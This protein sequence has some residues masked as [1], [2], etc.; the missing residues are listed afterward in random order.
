MGVIW[1]AEDTRLGRTVALKLLTA[2]LARDPGSKARFL[3]EARTAST[4]DHVNVCSIYEVGE[5]ADLQLYLAMPFYE[6]ETLEERIDRG[7]LGIPEVIDV[8][9]QAA[10]GL[11]KAHQRGIVHRDVKP[12]NLMITG[13]GVVKILDFGIAKLA[14]DTSGLTRGGTVVG[15]PAYMSPEQMEGRPVDPR[16]DLWSLGVVIYE[17]LTGCQ[18]FPGENAT[19]ARAAIL[20]GEPVPLRRLR[21]DVPAKLDRLVSSLL[22][23]DPAE[24]HAV[25]RE[26]RGR[27]AVHARRTVPAPSARTG[28]ARLDPPPPPGPGSGPGGDPD[29]CR[30]LPEDGAESGAEAG[31]DSREAGLSPTRPAG[32]RPAPVRG[33]AGLQEPLGEHRATVARPRSHGDADGGAGGRSQIAGRVERADGPGSTH[34][35]PAGG[36]KPG[37]HCPWN[38]S[39]P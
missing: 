28:A 6:G 2:E 38:A 20:Q 19:A 32:S 21:P 8:A 9:L 15:T 34:P 24:P 35:Q 39:T 10:R 29:R 30:Q 18:P 33:G 31:R 25:R 4:L 13:D 27:S 14:S 16:T 22:K 5:T 3:Q 1:R 7:P 36:R 11:G 37:P 12:S 26:R 17:A 23:K